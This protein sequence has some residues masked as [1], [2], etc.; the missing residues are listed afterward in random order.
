MLF[1]SVNSKGLR[2]TK[3]SVTTTIN[4]TTTTNPFTISLFTPYITCSTTKLSATSSCLLRRI[5]SI[6]ISNPIT[7]ITT[8]S[9]Y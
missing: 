3:E 8:Y 2:L 5:T 1:R 4:T 7:S 9:T 6:L